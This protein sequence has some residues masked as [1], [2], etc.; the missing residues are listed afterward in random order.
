MSLGALL[1]VGA[2]EILRRM[3]L[4]Q[5]RRC[6]LRLLRPWRDDGS[7]GTV[8]SVLVRSGVPRGKRHR[9]R[10]SA[11]EY[12]PDPLNQP[13]GEGGMRWDEG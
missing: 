4:D 12:R 10:L 6:T 3:D 2:L 8:G 9:L 13:G 5:V 1:V 11:A 7:T